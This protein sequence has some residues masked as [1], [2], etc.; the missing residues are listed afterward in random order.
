MAVT[1]HIWDLAP[2]VIGLKPQSFQFKEK[3][4]RLNQKSIEWRTMVE[5]E[6]ASWFV[7]YWT[8]R[9]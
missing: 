2:G 3:S 1:G 4:K 9:T 7:F 8:I 5:V 6:A